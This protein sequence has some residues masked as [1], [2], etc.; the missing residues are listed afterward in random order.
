VTCECGCGQP[1]AIAVQSSKRKGWVAGRPVRFVSGHNMRAKRVGYVEEDRDYAT[2]CWIWQGAPTGSNGYGMTQIKGRKRLA[3]RVYYE[4]HKGPI[5]EGLTLDH[6]CY[7]SLCVNPDHLEPVTQME[8]N[9]RRRVNRLTLK[10]ADEI[11]AFVEQCRRDDPLTLKGKPRE[12]LPQGVVPALAKRY[13]CS[14]ET[15]DHVIRGIT[16]LRRDL[17]NPPDEAA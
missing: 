17:L 13:G 4:R 5:P 8:N 11:R 12:R 10:D 9:R 6:L 1:T 15:I 2:P 7:V 3:H 16:W 14:E